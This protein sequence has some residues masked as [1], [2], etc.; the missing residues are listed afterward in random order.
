MS[1]NDSR[2]PTIHALALASAMSQ[3]GCVTVVIVIGALLLG[4]ALD[5]ALDTRPLFTIALILTSVPVSSYILVR[6][7]L[8]AAAQFNP[9]PLNEPQDEHSSADKEEV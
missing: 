2:P 1:S 9:P 8:S 7:A 3:V 4:L 6:I 5:K